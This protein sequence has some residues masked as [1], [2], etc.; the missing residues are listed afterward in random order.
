MPKISRLRGG[1]LRRAGPYRLT[2]RFTGEP[3]AGGGPP[4]RYMG[5]APDGTAVVITLLARARAADPAA[6]ARLTAQ[7]QIAERVAPFCAAR[8]LGAGIEGDD[9]YLVTEYVPGPTLAEVA[10]AEGA[11][12]GPALTA[13]AVG[14]VTGLAAI[15][16]AGLV[17]GE[18][19]PGQVVLGPDGPRVTQ[20]DLNLAGGAAT[21]AADMR[22]WAEMVLFC[23]LGR[24]P[25][26][27]QDLAAVPGELGGVVAAC[28]SPDAGGRPPARTVLAQLLGRH[29]LSAPLLAAGA[30][31]ARAVAR[32]QAS[33]PADR[34]TAARAY[35]GRLG[36]SQPLVWGAA[37]VCLVALVA[38]VAAVIELTAPS[39]GTAPSGPPAVL[40]GSWAGPV[41]QDHPALSVTVLISLPA[42]LATGTIAYPALHCSGSLAIVTAGHD[43][44]TLH[45]TIRTGRDTC[46]NGVITLAAAAPGTASF[47]FRRTGGN[48]TAGTLTRPGQ[49]GA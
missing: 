25:V 10:G 48:R 40:A 16:Q 19:G 11:Q 18:F 46:R 26:G 13:L 3:G 44:L 34:L 4:G 20:A 27:P 17:H 9:P 32:G 31:Q 37:S 42:G 38:G 49:A 35:L 39:A 33:G 30:E 22:A 5:R 2:G 14:T 43:R 23:A 47:S 29:D 8:I 28:L 45:Q 15:H 36:Q 24:P 6:R 12:A 1:D 21:P 7:A 41:H